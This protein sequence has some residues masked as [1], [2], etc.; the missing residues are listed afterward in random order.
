MREHVGRD[1]PAFR[2]LRSYLAVLTGSRPFFAEAFATTATVACRIGGRLGMSSGVQAALLNLFEQWDGSG[3]PHGI[4]GPAIPLVSRIVLLTFFLIPVHRVSG[5]AAA[6]EL[7]G[8]MRGAECDPD[9][10]DAFL[11]LAQDEALWRDLEADDI[12]ERVLRLEPASTVED[13]DAL[14]DA[15]TLA[16]ADFIDLKSRYTAAHSRRVAAVAEQLA[17]I[18]HCAEPAVAQ[19]RRAGL[20]HDL[21]MVAVPSHSLQRPWNALSET[22]RDAIRLHPYHGERILRRVPVFAPLAEMVGTHHERADGSGYYRG[23]AGAGITLGA[24]IIA[25]ADRLDSLTHDAP[26]AAALSLPEAMA[27]LERE[28][29]DVELVAALHRAVGATPTAHAAPSWPAG[30]TG[31]EVEVLRLA[32][33]GLPR[34]EIARRLGITDHTARHHLEHVYSKTGATNRVSA[35]LFAMEHGLLAD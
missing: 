26:G 12:Q 9:V 7:A 11:A 1:E 6:V 35:T 32:A 28:P 20:I 4:A 15:A 29:L 3:Q 21:G 17:R 14:L 22:E 2:R 24:R 10:V 34:R 31:R 16:F 23:L 19:I 13:E 5:R 8:A 27:V 18:M 33:R 30:L 25:V